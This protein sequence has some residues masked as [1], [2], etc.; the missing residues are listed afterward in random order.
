MNGDFSL[1]WVAAFLSLMLASSSP[2]V[3]TPPDWSSHS[4]L[5]HA[6]EA[7]HSCTWRACPRSPEYELALEKEFWGHVQRDDHAGMS[8]WLLKT[9]TYTNHR[10]SR[11]DRLAQTGRLWMLV[12]AG[13]TL[14]FNGY[15]LHRVVPLINALETGAVLRMFSALGD[16][17]Q[18]IPA[19]THLTKAL[20]YSIKASGAIP[21]HANARTFLMGIGGFAQAA[22]P[23]VAGV[24]GMD[25]ALRTY[26][27]PSCRGMPGVLRSQL[28]GLCRDEGLM[29]PGEAA[30]QDCQDA[31]S[32]AKVGTGTE[33]LIA[34]SMA[35]AMMHDPRHVKRM[36][37]MLGDGPGDDQVALCESYWCTFNNPND[38][39]APYPEATSIAPFKRIGALLII[40]E[41]Y[42][43]QGETRKMEQVLEAAYA[44]G[45]RLR[46][47][48]MERIRAVDASLHGGDAAAGIP[49]VVSAWTNPVPARDFMGE[50]QFPLPVS[51]R[52][53][54]CASCHFGG[55]MNETVRY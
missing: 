39:E 26:F 30:Y 20:R 36:L 43:K 5:T 40:A 38:P 10:S 22:L 8:R 31:E 51:G 35:L 49:D 41:A 54:A 37:T 47:P 2:A 19:L 46:Y 4:E 14:R 45:R 21:G 25:A 9:E 44:E 52:G 7:E 50:V 28:G 42:G 15:D 34:G 55:V 13:H 16:G 33:G 12:A 32:C 24:T 17:F 11:G 27:G 23:R 6:P 3:A 18:D 48:F 53:G 29:G 1:S